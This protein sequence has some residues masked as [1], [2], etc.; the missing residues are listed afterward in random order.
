MYPRLT[1]A[2]IAALLEARFPEGFLTLKD[3]PSPYA[4]KDM[5]KAAARIAEAV[6][7]GERI[8]IVGDYDVDGTV[9][10]ALM[11]ECFEALGCDVQWIVPNRFEDGYGL[12]PG[13][14]DKLDAPE[15][16]ITVDNGIAAVEAARVCKARGIE[17]II[18]DHHLLP[19]EVPE[20]YAIVDQKQPECTFP[21]D[22]VC[23]AQIAWYLIAALKA[24]MT[25][26]VALKAMLDMVATAV[27]ADMMPL[28]H[29]NRAMVIAG[30]QQMAQSTRPAMRVF[31]EYLDKATPTAEDI[32][33]G[34]APLLNSAGRMDDASVAVR[35]L[36]A[37]TVDEARTLLL[38]LVATNE[39]RKRIET[40]LTR[41]AL[42]QARTQEGVVVAYGDA[43]HEGVVGIVAARVARACKR[44]ALVLSRNG[45]GRL[46]GSG[47]SFNGCDLFELVDASRDLLESFGGHK[48]AVGLSLGEELLDAFCA[49]LAETYDHEAA[50]TR[51][52]E[53]LGML[54][55]SEISFAL[56][57]LLAKFEPYGTGNPK[58][59]FVTAPVQVLS[60]ERIGRDKTHVRYL[61]EHEGV[62]F[63]GL[64]FKAETM[65]DPGSRAEA[66]YTLAE[67]RFRG[68]VSIQLY[69]EEITPV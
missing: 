40:E 24:E 8:A 54:P 2:R 47:R 62:R 53:I 52:S 58:P 4:F 42:R 30:L 32:G 12:S 7:G 68:N 29:I 10:T 66:V 26:P 39:E 56:M 48:A 37:S 27:I 22:D 18:T 15:L 60:A 55:F 14:I 36:R 57:R 33:F 59:K 63:T 21:Y 65:C 11:L 23:G 43:W 20:A 3:L 67:N 34:L 31:L 46:K 38:Q 45:E 50:E 5:K 1:A 51:D 69:L 9:A 25:A 19:P 6:R 64:H 41:E 17:L 16:I 44:P 35:F 28:R 61:L 13:V 49:R